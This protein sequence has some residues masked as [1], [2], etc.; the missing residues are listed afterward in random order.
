MNLDGLDDPKI[1]KNG[2]QPCWHSQH[3]NRSDGA[4]NGAMVSPIGHR[5]VYA[6]E[7]YPFYQILHYITLFRTIDVPVQTRKRLSNFEQY[8]ARNVIILVR[9]KPADAIGNIP[10]LLMVHFLHEL[11]R[12]FSDCE[13]FS[14]TNM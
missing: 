4:C 7:F 12:F 14:T 11:R 5:G 8:D 3:I 10:L 13:R 9:S 2:T 1:A 6:R